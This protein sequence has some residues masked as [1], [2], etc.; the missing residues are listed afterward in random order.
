[1]SRGRRAR[2]P[3]DDRRYE[4]LINAITDYAIY[5]LDPS[6]IVTSWNTGAELIKGY[7]ADEIIGEHF[8]RFYTEE[9][10][11]AGAPQWA[12][13][14]ALNEGRFEGEG[15]RLRKGGARFWAHV[16]IDPIRGDGGELLGFA[17]ITRDLSERRKADEALRRSEERFRMLVQSVTDYAIFMLDRDGRVTNWNAGA[18]RIKGYRP[19]EIIGRHF[20]R[21][22]TEADQAAG[23]PALALRTAIAEGRWES[24]GQ[25][26]RKD[27]SLF[28]AHVLI[29]PIRDEDGEVLGFAKVTR[30][31]TE[32]KEAQ[33][34][35]EQAREALFQSQKMDA[36]GQ[37]TGG[38]AH[39]F[40]NLLMAVLGSLEL[41]RK[42]LP[43]DPAHSTLLENAIQGAQRG[44]T[45]TQRMLA[46]A[47]RQELKLEPV[48]V[49]ALIRGMGGFLQRAIGPTY[50]LE[51]RFP[52]GLPL[53]T[54]DPAQLE[55]GAAEPGGQRAR[56]HARRRRADHGV[57]Q[58]RD[59]GRGPGHADAGR[60][61]SPRRHRHRRGDGSQRRW[62]APPSPSSPPRA[63]ARAPGWG[64][65]WCTASPRNRAGGS[66]SR[67]GRARER[68]WRSGCLRRRRARKP[69]RSS[70]PRTSA[71]R[72]N[73]GHCRCWPSTTIRSCSPTPSPCS[74]TSGTGCCMRSPA[75]R[76]WRRWRRI[77]TSTW[78]SPTR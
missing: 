33:R 57:G 23:I 7:A 76:R 43:Y 78:S 73:C 51:V 9:D 53:A 4:L 48:D 54:T 59:R 41:L 39:D 71:S 68:R 22:Y 66:R 45:L 6:G 56:R 67:A 2:D 25:R 50:R 16:I 61:P 77:R 55:V 28:W 18:E 65:R 13:D 70:G 14:R 29:D 11:A 64:S 75:R 17:K 49:T 37:L 27:G 69:M 63:S 15:W 35:L 40:N 32:R 30:D 5:M 24:E 74:R 42:R 34:Q 62:R 21:F 52:P 26:V 36:L 46:F 44:A 47:R 8:S 19:D 60:V 58:P 1:M 72:V 20:S 3:S 10:R 31:I 38:I 12:L